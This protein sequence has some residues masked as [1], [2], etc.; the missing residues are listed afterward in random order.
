M[1]NV[2]YADYICDALEM[3][4]LVQDCFVSSFQV[5]YQRECRAG[6]EVSLYTGRAD[7][8]LFVHGVDGGGT[9]RF[10]GVLTLDKI[11]P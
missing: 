11:A 5:G 9:T 10:D 7:G 6:E 3:E 1:N 8:T 4:Q 2:K